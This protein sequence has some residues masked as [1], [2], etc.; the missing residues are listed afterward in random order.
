MVGKKVKESQVKSLPLVAPIN[1]L[2]GQNSNNEVGATQY[3]YAVL[4]PSEL[5][6][7]VRLTSRVRCVLFGSAT[8]RPLNRIAPSASPPLHHSV[9]REKLGYWAFSSG[10]KLAAR[11]RTAQNNRDKDNKKASALRL[12]ALQKQIQKVNSLFTG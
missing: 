4:R 12:D 2:T 9:P 8:L 1:P 3:C 11:I 5:S 10:S 7:A 6:A